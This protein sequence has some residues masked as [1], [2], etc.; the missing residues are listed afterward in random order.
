[1]ERKVIISATNMN[2]P[3]DK[4]ARKP[5]GR[6]NQRR[7]RSCRTRADRGD[8]RAKPPENGIRILLSR[9]GNTAL[10]PNSAPRGRLPCGIHS[11]RPIRSF[12]ILLP[13]AI[14]LERN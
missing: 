4:S 3:A 2:K 14:P 11:L 13:Q 8:T 10:I 6:R 9:R 7:A 5:Q 12:G 1:M